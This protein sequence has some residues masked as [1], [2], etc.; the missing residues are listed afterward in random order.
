MTSL[1]SFS[2][3]SK[4]IKI[5]IYRNIILSVVLYG[6]ENWSLILR[7]ERRLR[8]FGNRML[9]RIFGSK[10]DK[11][12]REWRRLHDEGLTDLHC[13]PNIICITKSRKTRWE[14]HV[15]FMADGRGADRVLVGKPE[16]TRPLGR[17]RRIWKDNIKMDLQEVGWI[18][19]T[20]QNWLRVW[21]G[22]ELF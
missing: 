5:K 17:H 3:I 11:V 15:K 10:M 18:A 16:R 1:L 13:S 21:K 7:E 2:L 12:T 9:K 4:N 14:G 19:W 20:V 8:V 22:G 6:C